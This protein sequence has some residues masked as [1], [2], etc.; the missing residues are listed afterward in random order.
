[1]AK[2]VFGCAKLRSWGELGASSHHLR[3]SIPTSNAD[4]A[5]LDDNE[6]LI[7][8]PEI[9]NR[10]REMIDSHGIKPRS[11]AVIAEEVLLSVG[12]SFFRPDDPELSGTW[13]KDRLSF[14]RKNAL[15]FL[16]ENF[17]DR[18]AA[19]VLHLDESTPHIQA[20]IVPIHERK[21][22]TWGLNNKVTFNPITMKKMRRDYQQPLIDKYNVEP[23]DES[24][25][26]EHV[27]IQKIYGVA[28]RL[29]R[30]VEEV[31]ISSRPPVK[32]KFQTTADYN[33]EVD[34][35]LEKE[36]ELLNNS[37]SELK[38]TAL[39]GVALRLATKN[40][41]Q[42]MMHI[43]MG[44]NELYKENNMLSDE[45]KKMA[46][47]LSKDQISSLRKLNVSAVADR[48]GY[49][50]EITK[51][52]NAIDLVKRINEFSY[53]D[54]LSWLYN[55]FGAK[56]AADSAAEYIE[57]HLNLTNPE[58][59]LTKSQ[60]AKKIVVDQQL[61]ALDCEKYRIT[62]MWVNEKG[63]KVGWNLGKDKNGGPEKYFTKEDII[64]KIPE[65]EIINHD[66]NV[67]ITP[68]DDEFHYI[69]IDD[70]KDE[71]QRV[72]EMGLTPCLIQKTSD[73]STQA[74]LKVPKG[75]VDKNK[76]NEFFKS[77]N[78]EIGDSKITGLKHPFRLAGFRNV[79]PKHRREDDL[80][81]LV[82]IVE[83]RRKLCERTI[84]T[85]MTNHPAQ[86]DIA[87]VGP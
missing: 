45:N 54:A 1:M 56:Q 47:L 35:W 33:K 32:G 8:G 83:A 3:R 40:Q 27:P 71:G 66:K 25:R 31:S 63:E 60:K 24:A 62:V 59:P 44:Y 49:Y 52:E 23:A 70:L 29:D 46:E 13:R 22:G 30:S 75:K 86:D 51:G 37:V 9:E 14:F 34:L 11:N 48:L 82:K 67:F 64:N 5:R 26:L 38:K 72:K 42:A 15:R 76:A 57:R 18:V 7:G 6:W 74:V 68:I 78:R 53:L 4:P 12:P 61:N 36:N 17:G 73:N 2:A 69:L 84:S 10:V 85:I 41:A 21:D 65:L 43:D 50:G 80:F 58:K 20:V 77:I 16:H 19:A 55:E 79:K 87:N 81:P 28:E 39:Q